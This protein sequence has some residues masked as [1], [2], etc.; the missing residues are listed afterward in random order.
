[1]AIT[2]TPCLILPRVFWSPSDWELECKLGPTAKLCTDVVHRF[3]FHRSVC[4][5]ENGVVGGS[6]G[7][8]EK[9]VAGSLR[10]G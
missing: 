6:F 10:G 7:G 4:G 1:M 5:S 3:R 2:V 8:V 9:S